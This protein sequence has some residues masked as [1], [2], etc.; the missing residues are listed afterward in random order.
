MVPLLLTGCL[1]TGHLKEGQ[2]RLIQQSV[3]APAGVD[4]DA[5]RELYAQRPNR[6]FLGLP[7]YHLV[8]MYYW[9]EK[10]YNRE[11][12]IQK[13]EKVEKK[14]DAKIAKTSSQRKI[15]NYQFR[16]QKKLDRL[17]SF[18]ENG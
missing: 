8:A 2:K 4:E 3:K 13:K 5:L 11:K 9:G 12:Y 10:N 14:F 15:N 18:I 7:I 1:G 17:N 6:R 16:K